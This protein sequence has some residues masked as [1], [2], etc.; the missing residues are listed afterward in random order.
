MSADFDGS[1]NYLQQTAIAITGHPVTMACW[2]N[3]DTITAGQTLLGISDSGS[4]D[5]YMI[6]QASGNVTGDPVRALD[7][8]TTARVAATTTGYSADTWH[9]A[10]GVFTS[11]TSRTIYID[12]GS[13]A[14]DTN[15]S[16]P[17][18]IDSLGVGALERS[19]GW[20]VFVALSANEVAS[21]AAGLF[22]PKLR[23]ANLKHC[24]IVDESGILI[25]WMTGTALSTTSSPTATAS[26]VPSAR[27][28][29][30]LIA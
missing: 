5:N 7:R 3:S 23:A 15:T 2:F 28:S 13:S 22:P 10:C 6:I 29:G 11:T 16:T 30:R 25:D 18:G 8:G 27:S 12:G 20:G 17:T 26:W 21:L 1:A 24:F 4:T 14:T 19:S 9:H